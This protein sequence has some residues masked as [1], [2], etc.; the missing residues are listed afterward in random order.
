MSEEDVL[1]ITGFHEK[2]AEFGDDVT[3]YY[4]ERRLKG[5]RKIAFYAVR[6]NVGSA[7]LNE[8]R[9]YREI[10]TFL[11]TRDPPGLVLDIHVGAA[12]IVYGPRRHEL[13]ERDA[14]EIFCYKVSVPVV[15]QLSRLL[16]SEHVYS[17]VIWPH[18][19]SRL[20]E[21]ASWA[22]LTEE[23]AEAQLQEPPEDTTAKL[24]IPTIVIEPLLFVDSLAARDRHYRR[25][26][27]RTAGTVNV[28]YDVFAAHRPPTP[29]SPERPVPS[30][31]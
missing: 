15:C 13:P 2:E 27:G 14:L 25:R 31:P 29:T 21:F 17:D 22:G 1:A 20:R 10:C 12:E 4:E 11:A 30:P 5:H 26:V 7:A 8:S 9:A 28:C 3:R 24:G 18:S 16:G 19:R 23:E 6:D